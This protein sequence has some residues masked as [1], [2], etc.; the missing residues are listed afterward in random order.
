MPKVVYISTDGMRPDALSQARTPNLHA[1]MRRGS[2]SLRACSV[3][4]SIS[5][6]CHMSIF[7]AVPPERHGVLV[8]TYTPMARPV[9]SLVEVLDAMG[10]RCASFF[11][12][13]PL[14]DLS[15]PGLLSHSTFI[16]YKRNPQV[17]DDL[18]VDSAL[19]HLRSGAFDF[20]FLYLAT[21]DEVGHDFG[22]M[23]ERYLQQVEHVDG[24]V[25]RVLES[26]GPDT[27]VVIHSDHGGHD[28]NHGTPC[29]ED[30]TIPWMAA[31]PGI[32]EG[33]EIERE[34][35]LLDTAPTIIR[36]LGGRP[37]PLWEG[38]AVEE[39]FLP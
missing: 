13:E 9:P 22:W 37:H 7:H 19:P 38:R 26:I 4:P 15:R 36:I 5:L 31:G 14:R 24:L 2:F 32:R 29:A 8:N 18:I 20:V 34:I 39:I 12:W 35:G 1:F 6:P 30:M 3:I 23:S 16:A 25:G 11:S 28:R 27:V 10:K 21:I 33:F 17:A